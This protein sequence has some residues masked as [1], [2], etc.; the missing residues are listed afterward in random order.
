MLRVRIAVVLL[1]AGYILYTYIESTVKAAAV[2]KVIQKKVQISRKMVIFWM[3]FLDVSV[4]FT[5]AF[6]ALLK[7]DLLK[8]IF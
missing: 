6:I 2:Q 5:V 4:A 8:Y 1:M 7:A 3:T